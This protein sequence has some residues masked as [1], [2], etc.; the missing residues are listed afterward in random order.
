MSLLIYLESTHQFVNCKLG[1][2]SHCRFKK[3][4][5]VRHMN[6]R[7]I[8]SNMDMKNR[9]LTNKILGYTNSTMLDQ[10]NLFPEL[11]QTYT[12][13]ILCQLIAGT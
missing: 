9:L 7:E 12:L 6:M 1:D 11:E 13:H 10:N 3:N 4:R 5:L 8:T 2:T